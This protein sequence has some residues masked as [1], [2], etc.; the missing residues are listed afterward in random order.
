MIKSYLFL[1]ILALPSVGFNQNFGAGGA[2]LYNFQSEGLGA[3]VRVNF[4]PNKRLSIVPQYSRYFMGLSDVQVK[5]WTI[6]LSVELKVLHLNK[7]NFYVLGHA[8]YNNWQNPEESAIQ[9]PSANNL[10]GEL[11]IG[12]TTNTCLRPFIEY[13]YNFKFYET[14][15]Q[16]G[17]LYVFGCSS[18]GGGYR[19][20]A[21]MKKGVVCPSYK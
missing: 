6:G 18:D 4:F 20:S 15:L 9:N 7:F 21:R 1:I 13:R 5:E 19:N 3:G 8:G 12:I 11:G 2:A 10:N 17:F 14:H 16:L